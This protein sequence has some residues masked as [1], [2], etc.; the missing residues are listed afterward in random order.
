MFLD[1]CSRSKLENGLINFAK[2]Q[3][4]ASYILELLVYQQTPYNFEPVMEIGNYVRNWQVLQD[5]ESYC[6]SLICEPRST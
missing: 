1:T 5:E 2:Y 4:I 6:E 3:K